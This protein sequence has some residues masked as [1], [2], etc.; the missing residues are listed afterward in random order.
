MKAKRLN[1]LFASVFA[2]IFLIGF[3]SAV[4]LSPNSFALSKEGGSFLV[5]V[6]STSLSDTVAL[7]VSQIKDSSNNG[8]TFTF[9]NN[10]ILDSSSRLVNVTYAVPSAFNFEFPSEYKATFTADSSNSSDATASLSFD[11]SNFCEYANH[12]S[13]KTTVEDV[14]VINGFGDDNEWFAFDEVEVELLIQNNGNED[15]DNIVVEW[16]LYNTQSKEWTIE[17][18]DETDFDLNNDDEETVMITFSL[19]DKLD[20]DLQ[21]LDEGDYVLY[22]RATGEI[23]D[24]AYEGNDTCSSD[25]ETNSLTLEK[26]FVV[27]NSIE[28]PEAV[29]CNSE[30]QILAD[31]WNIGSRDQDNVYVNVYNK[32]LKIDQDVDIGNIDSFDS[33]DFIFNLQLPKDVQEKK[34]YLTFTVY[35]EDDDVYE[36]GNND[37][38][39]FSAI[40]LNVTGDCSLAKATVSAVLESGGEAGRPLVVKAT[41]TNTGDKTNTYLL[42]AAGYTEW[43]SS[44][45]IDKG[46]LTLDAGKSGDV[47]LTFN[48]K[49]EALGVKLFNIEVLS[50]NE[51]VVSQPVQ[52]DITKKTFGLGLA[53]IKDFFSGN[54]KYIW[55]IA[56]LNLILIVLIIVIAVRV[57]RKN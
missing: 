21:D 57:S 50:R 10:F 39:V 3:A 20:E 42:D 41:I 45:T 9:S 49:K 24:G 17:V 40:L 4:T 55:G 52:V 8:V 15:V 53:G 11:N 16:G 32:E 12:G 35:D 13:L 37:K 54:N 26:D 19:N 56:I 36:N 47:L 22:V 30:I 7:S 25:S 27:L 5:N 14:K 46:S 51:L 43:A 31:V 29:Q 33:S 44:A 28:L 34:Y 1:I 23:K 6:S 48:V 2:L 38:S 18:D